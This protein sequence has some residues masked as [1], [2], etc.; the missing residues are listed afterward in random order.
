MYHLDD[1]EH[2]L[3]ATSEI[4]CAGIMA[5]ET[6]AK[7]DL[8]KKYV[9]LSHCYRKEAGQGQHSRGLYRLH[10]F[11]KVEMFAFT[12][13]DLEISNSVHNEMLEIQMELYNN[14]GIPY[15]V[16]DMPT[17]ELG[18]AA[19]RKYDIESYMPSK[20]GYGEISS[21]SNCIDYQ[22]LRLNCLYFDKNLEKKLMHTINGKNIL[23]K[24]LL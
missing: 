8:P 3:I 21:T 12:E 11:T 6:I 16:I 5:G 7:K 2:S 18:N 13:G 9:C 23:T 4:A 20:Q 15:R 1:N 22:A 24:E 17:E 19:F 10:Q 14:L